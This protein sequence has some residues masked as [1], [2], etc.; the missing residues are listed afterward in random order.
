MY[1][2]VRLFYSTQEIIDTPY[3]NCKRAAR[4]IHRQENMKEN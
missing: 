2:Q 3:M 4:N 1:I